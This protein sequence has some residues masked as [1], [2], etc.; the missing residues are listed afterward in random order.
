MSGFILA[1]ALCARIRLISSFLPGI[2]ALSVLYFVL[3]QNVASGSYV[4]VRMPIAAALMLLASM[5][6]QILRK[7]G[8][9]ILLA[10]L[11]IALFTKQVAIATLWRSLSLETD[12]LIHELNAL[13]APAIIM[14]S[15][16]QIEAGGI[17][18]LY[19]RHQPSLQHIAS[20]AAFRDSRFVASEFAI[21]GQQ[22]IGVTLAYLP[23]HTLQNQFDYPTCEPEE[24]RR[25]LGRLTA[26]AH[27]ELA[28]GHTVLPIFYL[29]IRPVSPMAPAPEATLI[30]TGPAYALYKVN[31]LPR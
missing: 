21:P 2:A 26:L 12:G 29:L 31:I 1:L 9:A 4:D 7:R 8:A 13:P 6:V 23:Y 24:S 3:P 17:Q 15:E 27:S 18:G 20:M 25:R 14:Q 22:P 5:D 30:S 28:A 10:V 11:A 16:C 19:A